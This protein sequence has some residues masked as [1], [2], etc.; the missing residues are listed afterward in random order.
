MPKGL[1][2]AAPASGSG[3]TL[4]TLGLL[5]A[6]T[7]R[8]V[9]V[10]GAK[11]GPDYIDPRFH[12]AACGRSSVN[13]D[14][15]AMDVD[16]L[17]CRAGFGAASPRTHTSPLTPLPEGGGNART[18]PPGLPPL[19][20]G[21]GL[22]ERGGPRRTG[23]APD[24]LIVEGAMGVLDGAGMAGS[25]SAA[26]LAQ[27]LDLPVVMVL[28]AAKLAQSAVLPVAG[29]AAV[30]PSL[31]L[32]GAILNRVGS[33]RHEAML[34]AALE[35]TGVP[36]FGAIP[37]DPSLTLPERHLG[38]VQASEHPDLEAFLDRAAEIVAG[39]FDLDALVRAARPLTEGGPVT[40]LAPLGQR[41]AVA[42]DR[43]FAFLYPHLLEDWRMQGAELSFFSPLA[44]EAPASDA[45]AVFLP[46]GYPEL[47]AGAL[48]TADRFRKGMRT[49][50]ETALIYGECG[51]Y[52]TLGDSLKDADGQTHAMLG[53]LPLQTSFQTRHLS[54]GYRKLVDQ[55][56]LLG[57]RTLAAHEFHYAT[58]VNEG[59]ADPLFRAQDAD[60]ANLPPMGLRKARV[61]GSFAHVIAPMPSA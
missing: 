13:L 8:G 48:A 35:K 59:R 39:A 10:A 49:A 45:D 29:L 53:L 58:I 20:P 33:A 7:R 24:L 31:K 46:G 47:H 22:G 4:L 32:A 51:G 37:R 21:E 17:R 2:I 44:D 52:M 23:R 27:T 19:P 54:L 38:L 11:S 55:S 18:S 56:A 26:D 43:A 3:K 57:A 42:H 15:W 61:C 60:G 1:V 9:D 30:R 40:R 50:A 25:G 41:I 36:V 16:S 34:T 5:R 14:A 6:L 28:D 12:E